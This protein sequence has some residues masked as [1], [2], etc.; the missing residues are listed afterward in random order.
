[1]P[2]GRT[3]DSITLWSLPLVAGFTYERTQSSSFTL[4]MAGGYLFSGLMFGPDLDVYSRQYLRWGALR[5]IW[6]PYRRSMRHRSFFS[7]G[8]VVGTVVRVLYLLLWLGLVGIA[9]ACISAIASQLMGIIEHWHI[10]AHH[11]IESS[12][13]FLGQ[14]IQ[15]YP[16]E[17]LTLGI[18]LELG[19]L[20]HSFSD[21]AVSTYKRHFANP[22]TIAKSRASFQVRQPAS[23]NQSTQTA[24]NRDILLP[25]ISQKPAPTPVQTA[26]PKKPVQPASSAAAPP[27][28]KRVPELPPFLRQ[29]R[30]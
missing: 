5:W 3:H 22:T 26:S 23:G 27:H 8:P 9:I 20:S 2:S 18:G 15:N 12:I 16:S 24:G 19:A 28:L 21:W 4:I 30:H 29:R 17:C 13:M 10:F 7:H 1:M 14:L 6:L 11:L 25:G